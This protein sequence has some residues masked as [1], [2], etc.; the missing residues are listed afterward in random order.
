MGPNRSPSPGSIGDI[1]RR[2]VLWCE[3]SESGLARVEFSSEGARRRV[4]AG[5]RED[6]A[7]RGILLH[8]ITLQAVADPSALATDLLARLTTLA[9][10]VVSVD[11]FAGALPLDGAQRRAALYRFN[12]KREPL[13]EQPQRQIWWLP[14]HLA[15]DFIRVVPDLDSWFLVKLQLSEIVEITGFAEVA[16]VASGD[17]PGVRV[18]GAIDT[19]L[20]PAELRELAAAT[21]ERLQRGRQQGLTQA[22][23]QDLLWRALGFLHQ[24]GLD[25]EASLL[26]ARFPDL[27]KEILARG[28]VP[29]RPANLPFA[30][31]GALFKGRDAA[32]EELAA[33]LGAVP[34]S[35]T[36][37]VARVI[38]GIGGVGKTRLAL[39]YA[40]QR[41]EDYCARLFV[42]AESPAA[43]QRN[44]AALCR[45]SVLDLPEQHET[46]QGRQYDAVRAW[47]CGHPGWLL[48]VD[49]VDSE[50]AAAAVE[51]LLPQLAGGHVVLGSRLA[52]WR[53]GLA[54]PALD[55]LAREAAV[56]FLLERSRERRR[57]LANDTALA[58]QLA[59]ELGGLA[60]ALE[61]AGAYIAQRRLSFAQY[62]HEWQSQREKVLAWY[63]ERLM[64]YPKSVAVTWQTSF[65]RLG[66]PARRLLQR[67]AW[68]APEPIPESL[69]AVVLPEDAGEARATADAPADSLAA[70]RELESYSLVR[71]A[72]DAPSFTIHRLLQ[73][74]SRR[75][76]DDA[77]PAA[78]AT[79]RAALAWVDAAFVGD[80]GDV[81]HWPRLDPLAPHALAVANYADAAGIADPTARLL[82]E[83]GV[84]LQAKA[85]YAEAEP[86]LRRALAIDE[87][88]FGGA[89]PRVAIDLNNLAQLLQATNR[90]VEAEPLMRRALAIDE[91]SFGDAHPRV[92]IR[93]NNL[94]QLLQATN[95]L[96]EA[97]PLLRR[98]RRIFIASLGSEH[99]NSRIVE[100]NTVALLQAMGRSDDE[101][102][103]CLARDPGARA[104]GDA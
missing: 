37:V 47:L 21:I 16:A 39:E 68:L 34:A 2:L 76:R 18:R 65:D 33:S 6:L 29:R 91:A 88:S 95:R 44:L 103:D 27:R 92:A 94:A 26:A 43:L 64:Q 49:N 97:E 99:P 38:N 50:D 58:R 36:A 86:L 1:R 20:D 4:V 7:A 56:D 55:V 28:G 98:A 17:R 101:I 22:E 35:A 14:P 90:L 5:L 3:R 10:G 60:L 61:Q 93:L 30:S 52:N 100:A 25:Q 72:S 57:A 19:R 54:L 12:L 87:A 83:L 75:R 8:E 67:L 66:E 80:P 77:M 85:R 13:G 53:G 23:A 63:D 9:P 62:L 89:H 41:G 31:L 104:D 74:V 79:L 40:W 46:D 82:N 102:A 96:A 51:A 45:A 71:R 24:G 84:L 11:G 69:L 42:G 78:T 81:R 73:E 59:D 70:L 48:I 15:E 32:L